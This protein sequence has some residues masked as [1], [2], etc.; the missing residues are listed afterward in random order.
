M[1]Q[2][3]YT[4][5]DSAAQETHVTGNRNWV[6][7]ANAEGNT[8]GSIASATDLQSAVDDDSHYL[9][10]IQ[11]DFS[12]V[13]GTVDSVEAGVYHDYDAIG[14]DGAVSCWL[15]FYDGSSWCSGHSLS[16]NETPAWTNTTCTHHTW[17][18]SNIQDLRLRAYGQGFVFDASAIHFYIRSFRARV[19]FTPPPAPTGDNYEKLYDFGSNDDTDIT[20]WTDVGVTTGSTWTNE[21]EYAQLTSTSSDTEG[22]AKYETPVSTYE[23]AT[24]IICSFYQTAV[25]VQNSFFY[26]GTKLDDGT[27]H[28]MGIGWFGGRKITYGNTSSGYKHQD[29]GNTGVV[30]SNATW[31][32]LRMVIDPNSD[33]IDYYYNTSTVYD[34]VPTT[35]TWAAS[36][37]S[38]SMTD[39]A[40]VDTVYIAMEPSGG[41]ENFTIRQGQLF[42]RAYTPAIPANPTITATAVKQ[43][44]TSQASPDEGDSSLTDVEVQIST[45]STFASGNITWTKGSAPTD[46]QTH[47]F[48]SGD[49]VVDS[50]LYY[51]RARYENATGWGSYNLTYNSATSYTIARDSTQ[52]SRSVQL[53]DVDSKQVT[54]IIQLDNRDSKQITRI[55]QL[56]DKDSKQV[57]R[58]TQLDNRDSKQV[59]RT[60]VVRASVSVSRTVQRDARD[61]KQVTRTIQ[62]D[63]RD[64][65]S[66]ARTVFILQELT[67][68]SDS[69]IMKIGEI[70]RVS[71]TT[72]SK[73]GLEITKISETA[74]FREGFVTLDI[75]SDSRIK[76]TSQKITYLSDSRIKNIYEQ[77]PTSDSAI[78]RSQY[79]DIQVSSDARI[80][81]EGTIVLPPILSDS[82]IKTTSELT[83]LSDTFIVLGQKITKTSDTAIF[84]ADYGDITKTSDTAI[85]RDQFGDITK[86]MWTAIYK[87]GLETTK[88][89]DTRIFRP[90]GYTYPFQKQEKVSDTRILALGQEITKK[91]S[92]RIK[93]ID[94]ELTKLSDTLIKIHPIIDKTSDTEIKFTDNALLIPSSTRIKNTGEVS[95]L[96]DTAIFR[97]QYGDITKLS[98]TL[99][100]REPII[101]KTSDTRIIKL[102]EMSG[103]PSDTYIVNEGTQIDINSDTAIFRAG[104]GHIIKESRTAVKGLDLEI[105]KLSDS[106]IRKTVTLNKVSDTAIRR[107]RSPMKTIFRKSRQL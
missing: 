21:A 34:T 43:M 40:K 27:Y 20:T 107:D 7:V 38:I 75:I 78:F 16:S 87:G 66:V 29:T 2:T 13:A 80:V 17:T 45:S 64:S 42:L 101:D 94:K 85:F 102:F 52:I 69:T 15:Y 86:D 84:Q 22:Y 6:N 67:K 71:D 82:R 47:D 91:S 41:N 51:A 98:D 100:L 31:L 8:T 33:N 28:S 89:S 14:G 18:L 3:A 106:R 36:A 90:G 46:P 77:N 54:R 105:T 58:I 70:N 24:D 79:G 1:A 56:D 73:A 92:T 44:S 35:W 74:I 88:L 23:H 12:G 53:D 11:D 99:I 49:G 62:L 50:T 68:T 48:T 83:K 93:E 97:S 59:T 55:T 9:R 39:G 57:T 76:L 10:V 4:Y 103:I 61:S 95:T 63:N 5:G 96:S 72:I 65:R 104:Y 30:Y 32:W 37:A 25:W 19:N 60:V 26:F 81:E